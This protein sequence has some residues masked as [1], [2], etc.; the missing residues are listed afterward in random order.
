MVHG[1][2][3]KGPKFPVL[4][5]PV[6]QGCFRDFLFF[7]FFVVPIKTLKDKYLLFNL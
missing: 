1:I 2:D 4:I 6:C 5:H 3:R 7:S